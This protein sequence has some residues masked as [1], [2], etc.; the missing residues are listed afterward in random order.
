MSPCIKCGEKTKHGDPLCP[1]CV[2]KAWIAQQ[3]RKDAPEPHPSIAVALSTPESR[4]SK[5][6]VHRQ[7]VSRIRAAWERCDREA[8]VERKRSFER[9]SS[10]F[11]F[12]VQAILADL[13]K[14]KPVAPDAAVGEDSDR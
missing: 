8:R 9:C 13:E 14:P 4:S 1:L 11:F 3:Q 2:T 6:S 10:A 5:P 12:E 7:A